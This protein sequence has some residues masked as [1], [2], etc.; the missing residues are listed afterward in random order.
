MQRFYNNYDQ[1]RA[2]EIG[3]VEAFEL[4]CMGSMDVNVDWLPWD[5]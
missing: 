4:A 5:L 2:L 3:I 1:G